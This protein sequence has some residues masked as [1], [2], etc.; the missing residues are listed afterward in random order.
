LDVEMSFID[1]I[2]EIM[3]VQE[4]LLVS[5][6]RAVNKEAKAELELL[7]VNID[8]PKLPFPKISHVDACKLLKIKQGSD[9][10]TEAERKLGSIVKRKY[11]TDAFF[12]I[13]FPENL[14]K[15]YAMHDDKIGRYVDL[16]YKNNEISSG[17]QREHR[18]EILLNQIKKK[19]LNPKDLEFYTTPFKYGAP[20][21]GGFGMGID[22]LVT[23]ILNLP[24]VREGVLFPRDVERTG[25]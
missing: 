6:L 8:V 4:R 24:N 9:I 13:N 5:V 11:G 1:G 25:P 20:P 14:T 3:R 2:K 22:R 15:F 19:R 12:L 23:F 10:G 18:Y 7:K 17:G 21:H 16:I